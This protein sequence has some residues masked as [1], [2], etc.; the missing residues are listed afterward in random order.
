MVDDNKTRIIKRYKNRRL[1]DTKEKKTIKIEDVVKLVKDDIDFNV[2]DN[3]SQKDITIKILSQAFSDELK[4]SK[5][6]KQTGKILRQLILRGGESTVDF[7]EKTLLA[8][9]GLFDLTRE[10]AEKIVDDLIKRGEVSKS[11]KAKAVKEII[12]GHEERMKKLKDKIDERVEKISTKIR[13]AKKDDLDELGK[14]VD[15]LAKVVE[16]LE[17][18]LGK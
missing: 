13:M 9:L 6:L 5:R 18:K 2:I 17:K 4:K 3:Q 15:Q 8:G 16:R 10:K 14:K 12:K 7:F 11:D 1:Y